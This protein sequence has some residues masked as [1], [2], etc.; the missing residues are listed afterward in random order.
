[1]P[2]SIRRTSPVSDSNGP[3]SRPPNTCHKSWHAALRL[4]RVHLTCRTRSAARDTETKNDFEGGVIRGMRTKQPHCCSHG[5]WLCTA[6]TSTTRSIMNPEKVRSV[7]IVV[8]GIIEARS[9]TERIWVVLA[10][11]Q[12]DAEHA[13]LSHLAIPKQNIS[14]GVL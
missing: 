12:I 3:T 11:I 13:N 2:D 8:P 6:H 4:P 10:A 5:V 7:Q 9:L 14:A 1:M